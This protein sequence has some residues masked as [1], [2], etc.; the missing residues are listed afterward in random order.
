MANATPTGRP[1]L[2]YSVLSMLSKCGMQAYYRYFEGIKAPPGVALHVGT[3]V[4]KAAQDDLTAKLTTGQLLPEEAV[5]E[6]AGEALEA[7]WLGEGVILDDEEESLGE[8]VV[9][10]EAKD[11]AIALSVLYHRD[12]APKL[13]L[14]AVERKMRLDLPGF[15]FDLEG[16]IDVETPDTIRDRK[17]SKKSPSGNEAFGNPQ[18]DT[19]A[20]MQSVIDKTPPKAVALDFLVKLKTAPKSVVVPGPAPS[21]FGPI[22]QRIERAANVFEKGTFYPVD[23]TGP[24]GWVCTKKWCG[25]FD[26]CPFGRRRVKQVAMST[27]GS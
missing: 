4:H 16:A 3:A 22:I 5:M 7:N 27:E 21:D 20:M 2:H 12:I 17:T 11:E 9:R 13:K 23:P 25:Y 1:A 26:R 14:V 18:L 6:R 24:S 19:Y 8:S 15:P 10:G